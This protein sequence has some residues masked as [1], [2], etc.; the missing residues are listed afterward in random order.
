MMRGRGRRWR[1]RRPRRRRSAS[2]GER[3]RL[4][5]TYSVVADLARVAQPSRADA[6][7]ASVPD[8]SRRQ[9]RGLD[10][11][12][13]TPKAI[14]LLVSALNCARRALVEAEADAERAEEL[15]LLES[16]QIGTET[17]WITP[18]V[19]GQNELDSR[20]RSRRATASAAPRTIRHRA[21]RRDLARACGPCRSGDEQQVGSRAGAGTRS[22]IGWTVGGSLVSTAA[23]RLGRSAISR[24]SRV[25]C[26]NERR[27]V[28]L[29]AACRPRRGRAAARSRPARVDRDVDAVDRHGDRQHGQQ[30]AA[31][32]DPVGERRKQP[33]RLLEQR[34]S[35]RRRRRPRRPTTAPRLGRHRPRSRRRRCRC[36]A[37]RCRCR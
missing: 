10:R 23:L 30:R 4:T 5:A 19:C 37:A 20:A 14:S 9:R 17:T 26:S 32:E 2:S 31:E 35:A 6:A 21:W 24:A 12:R 33:H 16:M 29:D 11:R 27:A 13:P 7:R 18:P 3:S 36:R 25:K 8:A 22:A 1:R 15:G 34:T 28:L